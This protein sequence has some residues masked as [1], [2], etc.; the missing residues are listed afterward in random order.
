MMK[1]RES[2]QGVVGVGRGV[3]LLTNDASCISLQCKLAS[4]YI[5]CSPWHLSFFLPAEKRHQEL[6]QRKRSIRI[7][8]RL[9]PPWEWALWGKSMG[10]APGCRPRHK[11]K[12]PFTSLQKYFNNLKLFLSL[13]K[14]IQ[15]E[16]KTKIKRRTHLAKCS[17][18]C[19]QPYFLVTHTKDA[20]GTSV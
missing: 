5:Y 13:K 14:R 15:E 2:P 1:T 6:W 3:L 4:G 20:K 17:K 11:R 16:L 18:H 8:R 10:L 7:P 12:L 19:I 9:Q